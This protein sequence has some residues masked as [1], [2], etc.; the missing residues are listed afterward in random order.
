[1]K[2]IEKGGSNVGKFVSFFLFLGIWGSL[3]VWFLCASCHLYFQPSFTTSASQTLFVN[4]LLGLYFFVLGIQYA[5]NS[6]DISHS[7]T[8]SVL[9]P[10]I[11]SRADRTV[12][13]TPPRGCRYISR[14]GWN[15]YTHSRSSHRDSPISS[16]HI[17]TFPSSTFAPRA[18]T[19]RT[20]SFIRDFIRERM[21][22]LLCTFFFPTMQTSPTGTCVALSLNTARGE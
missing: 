18:T 22:A 15:M 10:L 2:I 4:T 16:S 20:A 1:M 9:R 6:F 8:L 19:S 3:F 12:A 11:R 5:V 17:T 14:V 21:N 7:M 13:I